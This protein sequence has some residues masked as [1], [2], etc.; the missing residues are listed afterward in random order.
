[1]AHL[2]HKAAQCGAEFKKKHAQTQF[3]SSP[4]DYVYVIHT[5]YMIY[6]YIHIHIII[7]I[8]IYIIYIYIYIILIHGAT[9]PKWVPI[10][11]NP[12]HPPRIPGVYSDR[13]GPP[14]HPLPKRGHQIH[15]HLPA[16]TRG[17]FL[18]A[19]RISGIRDFQVVI[20]GLFHLLDADLCWS[21]NL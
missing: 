9:Q 15:L 16:R 8:Y 19:T 12:L 10:C 5:M 7:C 4:Y 13:S 17:L 14:L 21:E 2:L 18:M 11:W 6:L 20:S 1:M 3:I